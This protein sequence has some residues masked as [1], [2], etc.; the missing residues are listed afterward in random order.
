MATD[1]RI[2]T[3]APSAGATGLRAEFTCQAIAATSPTT[4]AA[5]AAAV[6]GLRRVIHLLKR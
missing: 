2:L 4:T 5:A 1:G 6:A 3:R